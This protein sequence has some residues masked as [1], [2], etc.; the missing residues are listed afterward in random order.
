[1]L[2]LR[3]PFLLEIASLLSRLATLQQ[4]SQRLGDCGIAS[5]KASVEVAESQEHL[6]VVETH[7]RM[8]LPLLDHLCPF[9]VHS[10]SLSADNK[11]QEFHL[12]PIE[13][14]LRRFGI[15]LGFS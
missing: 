10:N 1:M 15:E 5:N 8:F 9:R 7:R 13:L 6:Q 11:A 14:T 3:F 12:M 4:G 2:L